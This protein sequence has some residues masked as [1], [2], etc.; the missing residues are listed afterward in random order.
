ML[1]SV[2]WLQ[3]HAFSIYVVQ[4]T[5]A[6]SLFFIF[7]SIV[8]LCLKTH[9]SMR[10]P[11]IRRV[12]VPH[13]VPPTSSADRLDTG[14]NATST[15]SD[16]DEARRWILIKG[17]DDAYEMFF[18]VDSVCNAWFVFEVLVRFMSS[19]DR[20]EF[21]R[22]PMNLLDLVAT[23]SFYADILLSHLGV[24]RFENKPVFY[25]AVGSERQ[26]VPHK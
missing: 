7:V 4:L 17:R 25:A 9:P 14:A 23:L 20:F 5:A 24:D 10:V 13:Q 15:R 16:S 11:T 2:S 8:S 26:R 3:K 18:Y 1:A 6:V 22:S 21:S 19:P 12:A